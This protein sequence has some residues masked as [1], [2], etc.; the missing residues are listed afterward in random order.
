MQER[1]EETGSVYAGSGLGLVIKLLARARKY[2]LG[3]GMGAE[4]CRDPNI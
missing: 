2:K 3:P 1:I 4:E